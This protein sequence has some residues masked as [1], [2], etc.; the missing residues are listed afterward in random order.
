M[1]DDDLVH[2]FVG[3]VVGQPGNQ[4]VGF[5]RKQRI[6]RYAENIRNG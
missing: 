5:N 6:S 1:T 2:G 4:L 3:E